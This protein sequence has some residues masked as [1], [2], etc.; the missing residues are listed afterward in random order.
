MRP[1]QEEYVRACDSRKKKAIIYSMCAGLIA[2]FIDLNPIQA[3][4]V[5]VAIG[6]ISWEISTRRVNLLRRIYLPGEKE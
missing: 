5:A 2:L 6:I 1:I 3:A 4:L